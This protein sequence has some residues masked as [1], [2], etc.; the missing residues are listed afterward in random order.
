MY[1]VSFILVKNGLIFLIYGEDSLR[2][3]G[4]SKS[5][6]YGIGCYWF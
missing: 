2:K 4:I 5:E 3:E 1:V 6:I